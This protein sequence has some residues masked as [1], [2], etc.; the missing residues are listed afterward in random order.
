MDSC[1]HSLATDVGAWP[2]AP[3]VVHLHR[4]RFLPLSLSSTSYNAF[5]FRRAPTP[6]PQRIHRLSVPRSA[7]KP[8]SALPQALLRNRE[9]VFLP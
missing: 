2:V 3:A 7:S 6:P 1:R 9:N 5:V 8:D 4:P